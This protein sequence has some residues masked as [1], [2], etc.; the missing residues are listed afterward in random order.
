MREGKALSFY[1]KHMYSLYV[2]IYIHNICILPNPNF[3][4]EPTLKD[5][6]LSSQKC[7]ITIFILLA[8]LGP[9]TFWMTYVFW[10]VFFSRLSGGTNRLSAAGLPYHSSP[11]SLSASPNKPRGTAAVTASHRCVN[12]QE[13]YGSQSAAS[14]PP[15]AYTL[16]MRKTQ[17]QPINTRQPLNIQL[18]M[19]YMPVTLTEATSEGLA[20]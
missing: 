5:L 9:C 17:H 3:V 7:C 16:T 6:L 8:L 12:Q 13:V 11:L 2:N 14:V 19:N 20:E 4:W 10:G 1:K 18:R 15:P